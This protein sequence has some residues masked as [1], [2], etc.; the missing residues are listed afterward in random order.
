VQVLRTPADLSHVPN[1]SQSL[2][3]YQATPVDPWLAGRPAELRVQ[4]VNGSAA[5]RS[6]QVWWSLDLPDDAPTTRTTTIVRSATITAALGGGTLT[7][8]DVPA[9]RLPDF[10]TAKVS[11][12]LQE[13]AA[14]GNLPQDNISMTQLITL[15]RG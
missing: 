3:L 1:A 12:W 2:W 10:G 6:V 7:T 4:V 14:N 9:G 13:S 5:V 15:H 11:V 8:L